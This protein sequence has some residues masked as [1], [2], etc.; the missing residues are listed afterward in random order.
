[1]NPH[2]K[3]RSL[4]EL[5]PSVRGLLSIG[6]LLLIPVTVFAGSD[7]FREMLDFTTG[8]LCLVSLT[9]SIVWGLVASDRLFL[10]SRQR[11]LAQAVHRVTAVASLGF[12]LLHGTVKIALEHVSAVGAL[13]PFGLGVTGTDGLIGLGSL[14]GLLMVTTGI[15]GAMRSSF[16]APASIASR[17]RAMHMLAYPAWCAGTVHG[18]YAGRAPAPWVV[19]LYSLTVAAVAGAIALRAAP[20]PVKRKVANGILAVIDPEARAARMPREE[21]SRRGA[22]LPGMDSAVRP[23]PPESTGERPATAPFAPP[24]LATATAAGGFGDVQLP[25]PRPRMAPPAPQVYEARRE[26][27]HDLPG[28]LAE[29]SATGG[30]AAAYRATSATPG[31]DPLTDTLGAGAV[32]GAVTPP[33]GLPYDFDPAFGPAAAPAPG[34]P[35]G[36]PMPGSEALHTADTEI[37]PPVAGAPDAMPVPGAPDPLPA[38]DP[39]TRWPS[40]SPPPPAEAFPAHHEHA[41][42]APG[43]ATPHPGPDS[44]TAAPADDPAQDPYDSDPLTGPLPTPFQPPTAGEPWNAPTGGLR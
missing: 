31:Q 9:A 44:T 14:A 38:P 28:A 20:L 25:P 40:P 4:P 17:W 24:P 1:M 36:R 12:L 41:P 16:A 39:A 21:R 8:V 22:P 3:I 29:P 33:H 27:S 18:L 23:A 30:M 10:R 37:L 26:A 2:R 42:Y 15:T 19:V 11:L 7:G 5:S 13:V 34:A 6:V 43:A 32:A 35:Y